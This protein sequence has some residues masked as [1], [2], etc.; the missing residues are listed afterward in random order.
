MTGATG[1][2]NRGRE[3]NHMSANAARNPGRGVSTPEGEWQ[4]VLERRGA[5]ENA[6]VPADEGKCYS[7]NLSRPV[8]RECGPG[9]VLENCAAQEARRG[10][11]RLAEEIGEFRLDVHVVGLLTHRDDLVRAAQEVRDILDRRLEVRLAERR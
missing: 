5:S 1:A 8:M 2:A 9:G 4:I 3:Q 7:R 6:A 10:S 11:G